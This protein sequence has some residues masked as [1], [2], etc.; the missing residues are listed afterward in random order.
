[1]T[2]KILVVDDSRTVRTVVEWVFHGSPYTIISAATASD[3][4]RMMREH[5]PSVALI[6][7]SLPDQSGFELCQ[8]IRKDR[9]LSGI[10][11]VMMGGTWGGFDETRAAACA[12]DYIYKPFKTDALIE[13]VSTASARANAR[14]AQMTPTD[15]RTVAGMPAIPPMGAMPLGAPLPPLQ[16][17]APPPHPSADSGAGFRRVQSGPEVAGSSELQ[18]GPPPLPQIKGPPPSPT[19]LPDPMEQQARDAASA[20]QPPQVP[21]APETAPPSPAAS[22]MPTPP[23][24]VQPAAS[25]AAPALPPVQ[26]LPTE[27]LPPAPEPVAE[28]EA[29][30]VPERAAAQP[31]AQTAAVEQDVEPDI[32]P[33][34]EPDIEPDILPAASVEV[35]EAQVRELVREMLPPIVK[36]VLAGLLRQTIGTRVEAYATKKIDSFIESE[37]PTMAEKAIDAQL[38]ILYANVDE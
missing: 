23:A 16:A 31:T 36:E 21:E 19:P 25:Q 11:L 2:Q 32:E 22:R 38:Q 6:D 27:P 24:E 7:Y 4:V 15:A 5:R 1:M 13:K 34:V 33:V 29:P 10:P 12:D 26:P 35:D 8:E 17:P 37:L 9:D 18:V 28:V 14:P 3:A 30:A 20:V